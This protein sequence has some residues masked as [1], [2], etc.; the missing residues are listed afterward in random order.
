MTRY[1]VS[2]LC[3]WLASFMDCICSL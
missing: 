3:Y 2:S 1:L